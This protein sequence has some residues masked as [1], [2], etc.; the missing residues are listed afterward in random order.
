MTSQ[1]SFAPWKVSL[2]TLFPEMFPGSLGASIPG[3]AL[4]KGLWELET[5]Q[6]RDFAEDKHRTVD[7]APFGGGPGMVMRADVLDTAIN[8]TATN[9][10]P[11]LYMSPRGQRFSQPM[12]ESLSQQD[13][14]RIICGRYEG[15]DQR[16]L[17]KHDI[18]EVSLGDFVLSGGEPAA[19]AMLDAI[20]RLLPGAL[21]ADS[22][23]EEESFTSGLLE[24]PHYTRPA[25]WDGRKVPDVLLSG[26]HSK[27]R[28][29][30]HEQAVKI[31][32]ERRPDLIS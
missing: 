16:L 8:A 31:T 24:Y 19:T 3:R 26:N 9:P 13:G 18:E 7:D 2:L 14:V 27:I 32:K 30:R 1:R 29:W 12:A 10:G 22:S 15:I 21:G 25:I 20:I 6:I 23:L 4:E 28:D 17:D 5:I 11:L